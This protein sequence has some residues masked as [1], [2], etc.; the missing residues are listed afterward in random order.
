MG[1]PRLGRLYQSV[2][3][4]VPVVILAE[5]LDDFMFA[6]GF[7]KGAVAMLSPNAGSVRLCAAVAAVMQGLDVWEADASHGQRREFA[8]RAASEPSVEPL[9]PQELEVFEL[10]ANGLTNRE[11]G[12]RLEYLDS[13]REVSRR[14][15]S[16]QDRR[17]NA[18]RG[19]AARLAAWPRRDLKS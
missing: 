17:R 19:R 1:G 16:G 9:T 15:D 2:P 8:N 7:S 6:D 3:T 12:A 4:G 18:C 11:I 14:A 10:M 13:H 5:D